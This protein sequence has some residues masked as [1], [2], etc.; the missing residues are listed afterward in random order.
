M[1]HALSVALAGKRV[2]RWSG[3]GRA[4]CSGGILLRVLLLRIL[5]LRVLLLGILLLRVLLLGILLLRVLL[6]VSGSLGLRFTS[7]TPDGH[8]A[9]GNECRDREPRCQSMTQ[10]PARSNTAPMKRSSVERRPS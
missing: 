3:Q 9:C 1:G 5:L 2:L 4:W 10:G 6:L 7:A 8:R